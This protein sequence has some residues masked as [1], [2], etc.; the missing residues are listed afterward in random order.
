MRNFFQSEEYFSL[1]KDCSVCIPHKIPFSQNGKRNYIIAIQHIQKLPNLPQNPIIIDGI[2]LPKHSFSKQAETLRIITSKLKTHPFLPSS[3]LKIRNS[4]TLTDFS[5]YMKK[6]GF[7]FQHHINFKI[8]TSNSEICWNRLS[9]NRK[10]QVLK[11]VKNGA[12]V[13]EASQENQIIDYYKILKEL[14]QNKIRKQ[15]P[16]FT[17]FLRFFKLSLSS[18]RAKLFLIKFENKIIGGNT[19]PIDPSMKIYEWYICGLDKQYK[20][21][22]PSVLATWAPIKYATE[23]NIPLFDFMGAG[24]PNMPYGVREF[25]KKF[26]GVHITTGNFVYCI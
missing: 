12:E 24:N 23:N 10:K 7:S 26:G 21:I 4:D 20:N 15:I 11:S 16:P 13:I 18:N 19:C 17:V 9:S 1:F 2:S 5:F 22:H 3:I 8:D 25:K 14:Y 6:W